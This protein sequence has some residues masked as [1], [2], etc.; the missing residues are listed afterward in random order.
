M[1]TVRLGGYLRG[2]PLSANQ[3]VHVPGYGTFQIDQ[4]VAPDDP[5][6]VGSHHRSTGGDEVC[7]V[8]VCVHVCAGAC[9]VGHSIPLL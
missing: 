3:L 2:A 9:R 8:H 7:C 1:G 5:C 4:V 6:P